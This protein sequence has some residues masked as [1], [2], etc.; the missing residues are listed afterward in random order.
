MRQL[1]PGPRA[2]STP[3]SQPLRLCQEIDHYRRRLLE[4]DHPETARVFQMLMRDAQAQL[5]RIEGRSKPVS[6]G[7][8]LVAG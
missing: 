8:D 3:M 6:S 2:D 1:G 5:D 7:R 4:I